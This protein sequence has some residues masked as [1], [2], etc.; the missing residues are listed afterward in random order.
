MNEAHRRRLT[1]YRLNLTEAKEQAPN[2]QQ[3]RIIIHNI[4]NGIVAPT[5]T[6]WVSGHP[7]PAHARG[8]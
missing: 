6:Y 5:A 8:P 1:K 4:V 3:W 7:Q 2:K